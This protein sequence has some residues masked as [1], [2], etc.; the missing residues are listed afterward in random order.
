[1]P[2]LIQKIAKKGLNF[3]AKGAK[4]GPHITRYFLYK[5]LGEILNTGTRS[6]KILS[7]SHSDRLCRFFDLKQSEVVEANY[8]DYNILS[9]PFG[10]GEFDYILSDQVL[11]HVE[12]NPQA[13]IDETLRILKPGGIAVHTTCFIYPVHSYPGDFWR[14][15]PDALKLL[16]Q[17]FNKIIDVGGW[18]NRYVW[19][20][21][22]LGLLYEGIPE[23]P[24]HPLH[25]LATLNE[26]QWPVVTWIVAQK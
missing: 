20:M 18:G 13:A 14:Y 25:K 6:G 9:L 26:P 22:G 4:R 3:S 17:N 21:D 12:G 19:L 8:P 24:Q 2:N 10:E 1:M 16:C 11:E 5:R 23:R 7:I 15:T